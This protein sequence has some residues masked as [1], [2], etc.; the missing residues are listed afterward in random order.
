MLLSIIIP[1]YNVAPYVEKCLA[2]LLC[3]G[4]APS[5][6]ELIVVNDG[7]T[8][9]SE[10]IAKQYEATYKHIKLIIRTNGRLSVALNTGLFHAKELLLC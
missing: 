3:Q 7:S 10:N 8:D 6:Y 9:G 2:S 1:V 5:D 4:L